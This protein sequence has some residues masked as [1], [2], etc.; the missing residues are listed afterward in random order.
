[1][2]EMEGLAVVM[3][4]V[5]AEIQA[6]FILQTQLLHTEVQVVRLEIILPEV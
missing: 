4:V 5:A 2:V 6:L 1:V 3:M